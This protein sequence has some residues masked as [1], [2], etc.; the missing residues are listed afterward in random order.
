MRLAALQSVINIEVVGSLGYLLPPRACGFQQLG[1]LSSVPSPVPLRVRVHPLVSFSSPP[2]YVLLG[3]PSDPNAEAL[4]PNTSQGLVPIRDMS[5]W[6][7]LSMSIPGSSAFRPQRFARSRRFPPPNTLR[8]YFIPQPR[9]GF[10]L[11]G[12]SS[13]PSRLVSSTSRAL[14]SLVEVSYQ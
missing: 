2:E 1:G 10:A 12:F 4:A 6:S 5:S 9:P 8:A 14:M 11:Q 3:H 13:L 7:P